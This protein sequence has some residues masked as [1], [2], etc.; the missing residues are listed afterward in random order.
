M[1]DLSC[2]FD[3]TQNYNIDEMHMH[4]ALLLS[5]QEHQNR[6]IDYTKKERNLEISNNVFSLLL[7][8][9]THE[10]IDI[11]KIMSICVGSYAYRVI[12]NH[13]TI[14]ILRSNDAPVGCVELR[15]GA[16]VQVKG[17]YNKLLQ[18]SERAFIMK[19]VEVKGLAVTTK[20]L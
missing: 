6:V 15:G 1:T 2:D 8:K 11:G 19:W 10:L 17:P 12:E 9:D 18:G 3:F 7:A 20:D 14:M 16:V 5:K 4:F 13:C